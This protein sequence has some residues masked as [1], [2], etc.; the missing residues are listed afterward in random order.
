[1]PVLY[2]A[3]R[4]VAQLVEYRSPKPMVAGSIPVSPAT[5]IYLVYRYDCRLFYYKKVWL[6]FIPPYCYRYK[7]AVYVGSTIFQPL[8]NE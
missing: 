7:I 1:M 6:T 5:N 4:G 8:A 2:A 3:F